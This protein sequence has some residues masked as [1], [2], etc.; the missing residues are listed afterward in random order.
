MAMNI[1]SSESIPITRPKRG[2]MM[3]IQIMNRAA[4]QSRM[5]TPKMKDGHGISTTRAGRRRG[6]SS[7]LYNPSTG[8]AKSYHGVAREH[9][10]Q[11]LQELDNDEIKNKKKVDHS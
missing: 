9:Y 11:S 7:G 8:L 5:V 2:G 10:Y 1:K 6:L 4:L 3:T